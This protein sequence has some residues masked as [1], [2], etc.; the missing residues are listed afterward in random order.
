[1]CKACELRK[2]SGAGTYPEQEILYQ[3]VKIQFCFSLQRTFP[4]RSNAPAGSLQRCQLTLIPAHIGRD[5]GRPEFSTGCRYFVKMTGM[6]VPEATMHKHNGALSCEHQIRLSRQLPHTQ[7]VSQPERKQGFSD[8][9][10]R[11][12]IAFITKPPMLQNV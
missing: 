9:H 4:D 2:F 11:R 8:T 12:S 5:F 3:G 1:M 6:S 7:S 10:F